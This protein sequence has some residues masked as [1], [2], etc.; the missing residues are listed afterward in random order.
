M[1]GQNKQIH[2]RGM[3][4]GTDSWK[5]EEALP[6]GTGEGQ[7]FQRCTNPPAAVHSHEK[8]GPVLG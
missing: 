4:R 5:Q 8:G 1:I 7:P 2:N 3:K 6:V